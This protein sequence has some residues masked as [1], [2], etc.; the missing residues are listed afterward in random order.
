V[1]GTQVLQYLE[2]ESEWRLLDLFTI[3]V[4]DLGKVEMQIDKRIETTVTSLVEKELDLYIPKEIREDIDKQRVEMHRLHI[5]IYNSL[6][7]PCTRVQP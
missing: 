4:H 6:S 1:L 2:R 5:Q 7:I 3:L